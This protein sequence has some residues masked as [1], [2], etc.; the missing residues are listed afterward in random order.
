MPYIFVLF[1]EQMNPTLYLGDIEYV[2]PTEPFRKVR[3]VGR[4][5]F[6]LQSYAHDCRTIYILGEEKPPCAD[7]NYKILPF[8]NYRL[9][10]PRTGG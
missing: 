2:H 10:L 9:Y 5:T 8:D 3:S 4:Y 6:G 7:F 1:S